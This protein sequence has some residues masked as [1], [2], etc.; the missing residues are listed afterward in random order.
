MRSMTLRRKFQLGLWIVCIV[1]LAVLWGVRIVGKAA[2]FH[3]FERNHLDA[4]HS[5]EFARSIAAIGAAEASN[6]DMRKLA[7]EARRAHDITLHAD[8]DLFAIEELAFRILGFGKVFDLP[9]DNRTVLASL[10]KRLNAEPAKGMTREFAVSIT[11]DIMKAN[12]NA[13]DFGPV[14]AGAGAFAR[15]LTIGISLLGFAL[16]TVIFLNLRNAALN[17][18]KRCLALAE[19][20]ADGDLTSTIEIAGSD[21]LSQVMRALQGM[22]D[23]LAR[24]VAQVREGAESIALATAEVAG[25]NAD[26]SNRTEKQA[27]ELEQTSAS[28]NTLT[29]TV[30]TNVQHAK[31][32][33]GLGGQTSELAENGGELV[34]KVVQTMGEIKAASTRI[35]DITGV[36]DG[37]AFQTNILALNAAVE[38]ARA[39]EQGR[40][41]AV[42]AS[43]V[44]SLAQRSAQAAREIKGLINDSVQ[45]VE[46]GAD[47]VDRA[48]QSMVDVVQSVRE[49]LQ[50]VSQI[51]DA[52]TQQ[53]QGILE[54]CEA[55]A[56]IDTMTQQNAALVEQ[57]AAAAQSMSEQANELKSEVAVF[58]LP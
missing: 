54:S 48:G 43:E 41:F 47:L 6:I 36:I 2:E 45:K 42:V 25:G 11:E 22:N 44:R 56:R 30:Q 18:L 31:E 29:R 52:G 5:L 37:I 23:N 26:L 28:M 20:I 27:A 16:I 34:A 35:A 13:A 14:L 55:I 10:E 40:G 49:L 3:Y 17:P 21:E 9:R 58:R 7:S 1:S 39:G 46:T 8:T 57:A 19:R 53:E 51:A 33:R 50:R 24:L 12:K 15:Q 4:I 32:A 38:A